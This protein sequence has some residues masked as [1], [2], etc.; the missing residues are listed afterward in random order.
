MLKDELKNIISAISPIESGNLIETVACYLRASKTAS[1]FFEEAKLTK[2]EETEKLIHF[3]NRNNLWF[4]GINPNNFFAEGAEQKVYL[5][6]DGKSI[7]KTNDSIFLGDIGFSLKKNNDYFNDEI[8][9]IF[10]DLHDEN[11]LTNHD[12]LFFVDTVFYITDKFYK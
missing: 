6:S 1:S 9:L 3:I 5:N 4:I 10:E 8:G 12:V 2:Q 11:V 7:L